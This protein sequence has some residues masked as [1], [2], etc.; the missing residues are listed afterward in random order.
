[1][2]KNIIFKTK[3]LKLNRLISTTNIKNNEKNKLLNQYTNL[4]DANLL[5][6]DEHQLKAVEQLNE[7]YNKLIDHKL[8]NYNN[9]NENKKSFFRSIFFN[10]DN[11][12]L[13]TLKG[14]YLYGGVGCGKSMLM[15]MIYNLTPDS[16]LKKRIHFN[17]FMLDIHARIHKIK[18]ISDSHQDEPF[19]ILAKQLISEVNFLFFDEFQVTDIADAMIMKRLFTALFDHG[20]VLFSTSNRK[21][22]D[23]Y[24]SGLQRVRFNIL[25]IIR[26]Y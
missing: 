8:D 6:R 24:K 22:F 9:N 26:K 7:F 3:H 20:L 21:P 4:I 1:M 16:K 14:I 17:K 2:L 18:E 25:V 10:N 13:E 11:K 19:Q 15:D 23:L 5:R 12:K